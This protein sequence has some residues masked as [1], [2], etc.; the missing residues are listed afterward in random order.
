MGRLAIPVVLVP[1]EFQQVVFLVAD[2][3][4]KEDTQHKAEKNG[5]HKIANEDHTGNRVVEEPS[6]TG[7][8]EDG[9]DPV[10]DQLVGDLFTTGDLVGEVR[11]GSEESHNPQDHCCKGDNQGR[12]HQK[13]R[14]LA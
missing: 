12:H 6:V 7:M 13:M 11:L 9:I 10:G 14:L 8:P 2:P 1:K 3:I 4:V 5:G